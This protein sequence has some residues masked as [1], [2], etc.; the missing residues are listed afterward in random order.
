MLIFIKDL[1]LSITPV[2]QRLS[3]RTGSPQNVW[4]FLVLKGPPVLPMTFRG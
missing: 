3:D 4:N 1:S 2:A